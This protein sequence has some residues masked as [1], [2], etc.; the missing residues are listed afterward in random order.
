MHGKIIFV[1]GAFCRSY[2]YTRAE[3]LGKDSSILWTG[4]D[5]HVHTGY[6]LGIQTAGG[7]RAV[8][9]Y[10]ERRDGRM[11]PVSLSRSIIR[12]SSGNDVA[13]VGIA[14]D[15]SERLLLMDE[16]RAEITKLTEHN[17]QYRKLALLIVQTLDSL[18]ENENADGALRTIRGLREVLEIEME[19]TPLNRADV[20][21]GPLVARSIEVVKSVAA[22]KGVELNSDLPGTE[23]AACAT[24][25]H[26][27]RALTTIL[28]SLINTLPERCHLRVRLGDVGTGVCI[29]ITSDDPGGT[30]RKIH[31]AMDE[32]D[33][34]VGTSDLE[35]N[36]IL[37]LFVAKKTVELYGGTVSVSRIDGQADALSIILP[38][39]GNASSAERL[40][41]VLSQG[42]GA[43]EG[44]AERHP[45]GAD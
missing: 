25:D 1:N 18:L 12:D 13:V 22:A 14:R 38:K 36:L 39:S 45:I 5:R 32:W 35:Q 31:E 44:V 20:D 28:R 29:E 4:R 43:E 33:A 17:Q 3:I 7:G 24:R 15:L 41:D 37:E 10:H 23:L 40:K 11:F 6:V 27:L 21:L 16:F 26:V 9:F 34:S 2:G 30:I 19:E 8:G 42:T